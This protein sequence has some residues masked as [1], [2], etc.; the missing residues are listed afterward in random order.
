MIDYIKKPNSDRELFETL[1]PV[2]GNWF[3]KKFGS[4]SDPQKY[5]VLNIHNN[6][7]TLVSAVTGSGKTL[8]AFSSILSELI[9][10]S[11]NN[12]LEDKTYAIYVS[13]LKALNNDVFFNLEQPLKEMEELAEK[14]FGIRIAVRTGDTSTS[15]RA[16]MA[17][18]APHV[19]ITTPESLAIVLTT[20]KFREYLRGVRYCI[21]DELH[22]LADNKRGVHLGLSLE[23][24]RDLTKKDFCRIGLGATCEPIEEIAQFLVGSGRDCDIARIDLTKKM[25][26]KV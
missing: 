12:L 24:L 19:F 4:F 2:V 23:R 8:T 9:T 1:N 20:T 11:E 21:V 17:R 16:K 6:R 26:I 3:K 5:A 7:N 10:L 25:D 14:E 15:E 22:A 13:P 18:K